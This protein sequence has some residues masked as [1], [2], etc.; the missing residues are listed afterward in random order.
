MVSIAM[1]VERQPRDKE[2]VLEYWKQLNALFYRT[3]GHAEM[4]FRINIIINIIIVGVGIVLLGYSIVYSWTNNLDVY[5]VAFG[6]LG[7]LNFVVTFYFTPQKRIQKT[8]GDLTQLQ[9]IY[10]TYYSQI[11]TINDLALL[12]QMAMT[13]EKVSVINEEFKKV[14]NYAL[15]Q[16]EEFLGKEET[17]T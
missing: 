15:T 11:E 16:L 5:S 13:P 9:I 4:A 14:T 12:H 7:V 1:A 6:S 17:K 10:R 2:Y 8:V 3:I